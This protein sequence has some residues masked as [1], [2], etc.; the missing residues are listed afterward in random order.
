MSK[1]DRA[2]HGPGW[3]EVIFGA[4]LSLVLGI[5]IGAVLLIVKPVVVVKEL[6][7]EPVAGTVYFVEGLRGDS[8]KGKQALAKRKALL[9]GQSVKVT[10]DEVNALAS[11]ATAPK[12]D[13]KAGN[14]VESVV[15]GT[16]NVRIRDG[17]MQVGVPVTVTVMGYQQ[18]LIAQAR[19]GFVKRGDV[20]AYDPD[21]I[22]VG[23]CPCSGCR[24]SPTTCVRRFSR[25][26]R[27]L[28]TSRRPGP[29]WRM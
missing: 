26:R 5:A 25:R 21:E 29:S 4:V 22:F 15:T 16:P 23:S 11:A 17:V 18:K 3:G 8:A 10:E 14:S 13:E 28:T 7:K 1:V 24:S 27:C 9:E 6:P 20:F 12:A 19:G 2:I